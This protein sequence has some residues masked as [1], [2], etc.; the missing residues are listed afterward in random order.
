MVDEAVALTHP[1]LCFPSTVSHIIWCIY[2]QCGCERTLLL[3]QVVCSS[4]MCFL[5]KFFPLDLIF[6]RCG[7]FFSNFLRKG[8]WEVNVVNILRFLHNLKCLYSALSQ[9]SYVKCRWEIMPS[10][11]SPMGLLRFWCHSDSQGF[12]WGLGFSPSQETL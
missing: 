12:R 10:P 11:H 1:P 6:C 3:S 8:T 7:T 5:V 9:R 2:I 4:S